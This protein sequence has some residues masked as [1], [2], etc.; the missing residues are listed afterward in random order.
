M[1]VE[2]EQDIN[3][4]VSH[5]DQIKMHPLSLKRQTFYRLED[6]CGGTVAEYYTFEKQETPH[7]VVG[8]KSK[9]LEMWN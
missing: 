3:T 7:T 5:L 6:M 2:V 8:V 9:G 4:E 1:I